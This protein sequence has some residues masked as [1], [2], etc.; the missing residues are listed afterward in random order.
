MAFGGWRR[1]GVGE[2]VGSGKWEIWGRGPVSLLP[3]PTPAAWVG[4]SASERPEQ[5][6]D[7][8]ARSTRKMLLAGDD[9]LQCFHSMASSSDSKS[10][11]SLESFIMVSFESVC[12]ELVN[13]RAHHV[14]LKPCLTVMA[15]VRPCALVVL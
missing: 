2:E 9:K 15:L 6:G 5:E 4:R 7:E 14:G 1:R 10:T 13:D 8:P 3:P 11:F 12:H